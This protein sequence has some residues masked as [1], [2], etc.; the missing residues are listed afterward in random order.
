MV[1]KVVGW[2][3]VTLGSDAP[4]LGVAVTRRTPCVLRAHAAAAARI[5]TSGAV[6]INH[7]TRIAA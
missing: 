4:H 5:A 6:S 3:I 1:H 7:T 2:S